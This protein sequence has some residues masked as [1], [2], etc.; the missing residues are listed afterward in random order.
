MVRFFSE[1]DPL[2]KDCKILFYFLTIL[3]KFIFLISTLFK[4]LEQPLNYCFIGA[5]VNNIFMLR[6]FSLELLKGSFSLIF[7]C[8][9]NTNLFLEQTLL[10]SE[11]RSHRLEFVRDTL[12]TN[13]LEL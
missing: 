9:E 1:N 5:F 3:L 13:L 7:F 2:M 4:L 8:F 10:D 12:N 6:L 11:I